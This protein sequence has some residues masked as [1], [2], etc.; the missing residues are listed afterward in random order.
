MT[1]SVSGS[2][3]FSYLDQV[4][5]LYSK[6]YNGSNFTNSITSGNPSVNTSNDT[7]VV[8]AA[9]SNTEDKTTLSPEAQT[10]LK[11]ISDGQAIAKAISGKDSVGNTVSELLG[12]NGSGDLVSELFGSAIASDPLSKAVIAQASSNLEQ[13]NNNLLQKAKSGASLASDP[14]QKAL[15]AYQDYQNVSNDTGQNFDQVA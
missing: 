13:S 4:K 2:A 1:S 5:N 12:G 9:A 10:I 8:D 6:P 15:K 11:G 14:I 3:G 7:G